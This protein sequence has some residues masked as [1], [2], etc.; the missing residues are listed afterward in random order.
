MEPTPEPP[1]SVKPGETARLHFA[2]LMTRLESRDEEAAREIHRR[3]TGALVALA[4]NRLNPAVRTKVDPESVI[5]SVYRSFF[6]G[7]R[8]G[9]YEFGD[10]NDLWGLLTLMTLRKCLNR[11][12]F[13][14]Q[15]RRDLNREVPLQAPSDTDGPPRGWQAEDAGPTPEQ[16]AILTETVELLLSELEPRQRQIIELLLQGHTIEEVRDKVGCGE[17]TVRR[18]RDRVRQRIEE[19]RDAEEL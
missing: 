3:Y 15:E 10:W 12:R 5:Q 9:E 17:R 11:A 4:R 7:H 14:R 1:D 2:D 16:A 18:V 19:M 13:H 6:E 8:A